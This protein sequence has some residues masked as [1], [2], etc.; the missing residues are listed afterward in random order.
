MA[1][2]IERKF[3][4]DQTSWKPH[5]AGIHFKQGYLNAQKERVVRVRIE[6]NQAK[7]TIKGV[8]TGVTRSEFEYA[9]PVEDAAILLDNLCEQPLIDKHRHKETHGGK[10]WEID[11]FHGLN[12][13]LV[14]AEIELTSED[15]KFDLPTWAVK[16]VSSDARYFNSNLLKNPFTAWEKH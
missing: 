9:I 2:E 13:G 16:E 6:G 5:D 8:T 1:K 14:V 11:V 12:E 15:E 3:L 10:A 4:V 7:L